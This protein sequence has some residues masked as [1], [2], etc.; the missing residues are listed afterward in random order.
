MPGLI[1]DLKKSVDEYK[2][3][4]LSLKNKALN[5]NR[6]VCN[7]DEVVSSIQTSTQTQEN[8]IA[9][10]ES[11][12]NKLETFISDVVRIDGDVADL[13]NKNKD[14]F[15]NEYNYLK[16][17]S[18]KSGWEK[19]CD[20]AAE[21]CKEHWQELVITIVI[22]VG[23]VLAIAAVIATGGLA[24]VP[25]LTAGL[26][27]LG[28]ASGTAI[29][30]ATVV[31][32]TVAGIAVLSTLASTTLNLMDIWGDYGNNSTFQ[33]WRTAMN[34]T[35]AATNLFYSVGSIYNAAQGISNSSLRE[36]GKYWLT[37]PSFRSAIAGADKFN[38]VVKP[39]SSTFWAGLGKN[40]ENIAKEYAS[41][42]GRTTLESTM[43]AQNIARPTS[44]LGWRSAS[45]SY[46]M[47]SSGS[48][49]VLLTK[50]VG[51]TYVNMSGAVKTIGD[52]W[53]N[54]ERVLL[55]INPYITSING[56]SRSFSFSSLFSG[57]FSASESAVNASN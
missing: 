22:V 38:M 44:D 1:N 47:H 37:S 31:S 28:V 24:L 52:T 20:S 25:M 29:T 17:D 55:N 34:W 19:F 21:W 2:S 3:E 36:Y 35:S 49:E 18:E 6:S 7:L 26:T 8:K 11:F 57:I 10:L 48:V 45:S 39:S 12:N 51:G 46:A 41:S 15:Y 27:A 32:L 33:A 42:A 40:G 4:L 54:T 23:A 30:I 50:Q 16:P 43:E 53:L 5:V 9:A 13:I 56:T 14:D